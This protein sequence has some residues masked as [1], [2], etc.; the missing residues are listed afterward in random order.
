M[1]FPRLTE[2]A[3]ITEVHSVNEE[4]EDE[5]VVYSEMESVQNTYSEIMSRKMLHLLYGESGYIS[6]ILFHFFLHS[7]PLTP[8]VTLR[9]FAVSTWSRSAASIATSTVRRTSV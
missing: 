3:F 8:E 7:T 5:G 9:I 4:G 2:S 1:L 6:S